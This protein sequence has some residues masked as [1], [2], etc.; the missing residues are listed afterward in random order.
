MWSR[1]IALIAVLA[2]VWLATPAIAASAKKPP[3]VSA[4]KL[5]LESVN[6]AEFSAKPAKPA[7]PAKS[8]KASKSLDP[9]VLK[10]QVLLDRAGFS[11]GV[12]DALGGEN[13]AKALTAFQRQNELGPSGKLDEPT[14]SKLTATSVDPVLT[15]YEIARAD[16][17]GP[18]VKK[19]P[20]GLEQ[21]AK[22]DGLSYT[23]PRELLSEKFHMSESLLAALN[24]R[25][26]FKQAEQS[27]VVANVPQDRVGAKAAKIEVD[28]AE[29]TVRALDQDGKLIAIFPVSI[30]SEE[31][32]APSGSY[33]VNAISPNPVYRYDPKFGWKEVKTK[34]K[35]T[36]RPGPNN[37][38]GVV[39][40]NLTA[41]SYGIHGTP[42]PEKISKTESHGCI[43]LTNW[44]V[45]TLANMVGK[46]TPVEFLD[47]AAIAG[48]Q[49]PGTVGQR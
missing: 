16:V 39:W 32:P 38:V 17:K 6:A 11:P 25:E 47:N 4:P 3:P 49:K 19:I 31:K 24:P 14:W 27:I 48:Q 37:P 44:D 46:G 18:F 9:V 41:P 2:P 1:S 42:N 12:I 45:K 29:R 28:K 34:N 13:F 22:L 35:L 26:S 8:D 15:E 7:K 43:R 5:T 36:I 21:M 10:A 23:G 30:G 20:Q 33:K 40:I